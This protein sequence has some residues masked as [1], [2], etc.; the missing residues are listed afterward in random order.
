[1]TAAARAGCAC[2]ECAGH[3]DQG[4]DRRSPS[5]S[6]SGATTASLFHVQAAIERGASREEVLETLGMAIMWERARPRVVMSDPAPNGLT[7]VINMQMVGT[8]LL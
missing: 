5:R 6:R 8:A 2:T 4:A 3:Q 1:M 7:T